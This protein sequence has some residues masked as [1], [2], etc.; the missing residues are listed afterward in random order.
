MTPK[1]RSNR[2][3]GTLAA[4]HPKPHAGW[5]PNRNGEAQASRH[6]PSGFHK[7]LTTPIAALCCIAIACACAC[8]GCAGG[9]DSHPELKTVTYDG[10]QWRQNGDMLSICLIGHDKGWAEPVEGLNGQ[11]DVIVVIALD[12]RLGKLTGIVVP[13]DTMV[14][15]DRTFMGTDTFRGTKNMQICL[16]FSYGKD[17]ASSSE[18]VCTAVSRILQNT[19]VP[20]YF[21]TGLDGFSALADSAGGI[22]LE[23]L[24]TI[25]ETS[26]VKG[27]TV[28]LV[29]NEALAYIRW[30]DEEKLGSALD[31]QE[32]Q[33]QFISILCSKLLEESN[34]NPNLLIDFFNLMS[35]HS[36]T[37]LSI[38]D[39]G[40]IA[41]SLVDRD[42]VEINF[43]SL[44]GESIYNEKSSW[45]QFIPDKDALY[46]TI[47]EVY[48]EPV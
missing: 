47:L 16:A 29:G 5:T 33:R 45:E 6:F 25:P 10:K 2:Q 31:R 37:N 36:T 23:A 30:R 7:L 22:T 42:D 12:K 38:S 8:I 27:K 35:E 34:S 46:R 48:Y 15:V 14:D 18:L 1:P 39:F 24:E 13:R 26:I 44:K 17:D 19:P 28:T 11:A 9:D 32:R 40:D 20:Y 3:P 43:I 21:T 41:S 4:H